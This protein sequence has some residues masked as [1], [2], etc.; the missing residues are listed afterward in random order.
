MYCYIFLGYTSQQSLPAPCS[1]PM[2]EL[3]SFPGKNDSSS[4]FGRTPW[5]RE[6]ARSRSS[7]NF[8]ASTSAFVTNPKWLQEVT[9]R[10]LPSLQMQQLHDVCVLLL[11]IVQELNATFIPLSGANENL[12]ED[13][14]IKFGYSEENTMPPWLKPVRF[15][16]IIL[17]M[18]SLLHPI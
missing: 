9:S 17:F 13:E 10:N 15:I 7:G 2:F 3:E 14:E 1:S 11:V 5:M 12:E 4:A 8:D 18:T 16:S 6:V